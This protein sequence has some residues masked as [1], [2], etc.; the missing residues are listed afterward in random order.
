LCNEEDHVQ[1]VSIE[2]GGDIVGTFERCSKGVETVMKS[3]EK[4]GSG[5]QIDAH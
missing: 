1:V 3:I 2:E 5:F 4:Q